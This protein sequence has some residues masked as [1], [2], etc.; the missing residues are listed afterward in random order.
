MPYNELWHF[1][2][3]LTGRIVYIWIWIEIA[4]VT[5]QWDSSSIYEAGTIILVNYK[6]YCDLISPRFSPTL[7]SSNE[8]Y[9]LICISRFILSLLPFSSLSIGDRW[10][11]KYYI[12]L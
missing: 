12:F 10:S 6:V 9:G 3:N 2:F 1:G 7:S 8:K 4:F 5:L 11:D